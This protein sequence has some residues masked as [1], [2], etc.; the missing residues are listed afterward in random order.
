MGKVREMG[1][2]A[3]YLQGM[4]AEALEGEREREEKEKGRRRGEVR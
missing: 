3:S 1:A 2:A 4:A